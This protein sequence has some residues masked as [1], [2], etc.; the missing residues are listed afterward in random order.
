MSEVAQRTS[1]V[2]GVLVPVADLTRAHAEP[3]PR[4]A[5]EAGAPQGL[6]LPHLRYF[7]ALADAGNFTRAEEQIFI[8]Q[9]T[10]SQQIRRLEEIVGTPLLRRRREGLQLTRAGRVLLDGSRTVLAQVDQTVSQTRQ[11]FEPEVWIPSAHPAARRSAISLEE[12]AGLWA[13]TPTWTPTTGPPEPGFPRPWRP[14]G[15][16]PVTSGSPRTATCTSTTAAAT[17]C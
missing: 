12:L 17:R 1:A 9:P 8:A 15:R 2:P 13:L 10:L 7:V 11:A 16:R 14:S 4:P 3:M 6:E 5:A